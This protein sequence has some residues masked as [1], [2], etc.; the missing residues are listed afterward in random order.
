MLGVRGQEH[1]EH[2]DQPAR[3]DPVEQ[4]QVKL[5]AGGRPADPR[6]LLRP[7][8]DRSGLPPVFQQVAERHA[9][10]DGQR[11]QRL[12]RGV[13]P[14]LLQVGQCGLGQVGPGREG[15][16][17][18][19]AGGTEPVQVRRENL[20]HV[21]EGPVRR[22]VRHA[23]ELY[24]WSNEMVR[25]ARRCGATH[26]V[27]G[28]GDMR[29]WAFDPAAIAADAVALAEMPGGTGHEQARIGWLQRRLAG[30]PGDRRVDAAGNLVWAFGPPP[31]RLA[32]LVHVDDVFTE[33]T[34]RGVTERDGW[35]CGPGIGDN[36][37]A[38][39]TAV[40]V[41]EAAV[42]AGDGPG[43]GPLAIV[44]TVGEEGAGALRGARHACRELA[45][46]A[47]LA[48][49]GHGADRV[50]TT[51]VGS[52][53]VR[54]TVTGP[55][56]HSWWDRGRPSAVHELVRLL[57]GMIASVPAPLSVNVGLVDGGTGVNAIAARAS[58]T[59][60]WRATDQ[61]ALDRQEAALAELPTELS[62]GLRL[63]AERL[64]RRPAGS[65]PLAH[66]LVVAVLRARRAV[67][68]PDATGDG[69]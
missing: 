42:A 59:V 5:A 18:H 52:L 41:A 35:L 28:Q 40:A 26:V 53:R 39:A 17:R 55:G 27:V 38:V 56:G 61:A 8:H 21:R 66:P 9:E 43:L 46:G 24:Q 22:F 3:L 57:T 58:A 12:D 4:S 15:G 47:V 45:P 65:L 37:V 68:L 49:E 19:P 10:P 20:A 23:S 14:A 62:P 16:Q 30:L 7:D 64:D 33:D 48:L 25:C 44:F 29:D 2:L 51:A 31:P 50:F 32:L 36:A 34:A 69:S 6:A 63:E 1:V 60:E 13:A 54:L 11:P 67:G